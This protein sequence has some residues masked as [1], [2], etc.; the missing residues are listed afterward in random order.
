MHFVPPKT[1]AQ[2]GML[3][4]HRSREGAKEERT[5]CINRI[6]GLLGEF[7]GVL[8]LTAAVLRERLSEVIE[9][10]TNETAD[11]ATPRPSARCGSLA[12]VRWPSQ[13]VRPANR[14]PP[15]D[16]EQVRRAAQQKGLVQTA[17]APIATVGD[18][19]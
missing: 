19:K 11:I 2:Q 6:R 5:A 3:C 12:R 9:D 15:Q 10:G 13:V 8:P 18:F 4:V 14:G 1:V 16:D 17:S 7:G